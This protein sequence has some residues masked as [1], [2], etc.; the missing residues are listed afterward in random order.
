MIVLERSRLPLALA[1]AEA[2]YMLE[3]VT[4]GALGWERSYPLSEP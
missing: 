3:A 4:V 2:L 1:V